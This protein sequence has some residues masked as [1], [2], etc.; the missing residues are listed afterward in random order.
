MTQEQVSQTKPLLNN[1]KPTLRALKRDIIFKFHQEI[2]DSQGLFARK[3]PAGIIIPGSMEDMLHTPRWGTVCILGP[4]CSDELRVL[5]C[6]IL[7]HPL[8]WTNSFKFDGEKFWK[9]NEDWVYGV[10]YPEDKEE[11]EPLMFGMNSLSG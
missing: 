10:R 7:I 4:K 8:K 3:S 6:E 2:W 1:T 5:G 11:N 9:T